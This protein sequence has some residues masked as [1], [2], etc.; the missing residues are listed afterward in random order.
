V[1]AERIKGIK[2]AYVDSCTRLGSALEE[3]EQTLCLLTGTPAAAKLGL[4]IG[5]E[6]TTIV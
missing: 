2:A 3:L 1:W 6:Q 5:L 4:G